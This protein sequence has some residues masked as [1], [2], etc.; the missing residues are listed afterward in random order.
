MQCAW[1]QGLVVVLDERGKEATSEGLAA[2][3]AK[4]CSHTLITHH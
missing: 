1:V 4:V 2:L 3:L